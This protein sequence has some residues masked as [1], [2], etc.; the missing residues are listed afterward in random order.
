MNVNLAFTN[1]A[2]GTVNKSAGAGNL[3]FNNSFDNDGLVGP[4]DF[5][6]LKSRFGQAGFPDQDLNGDGMVN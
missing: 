2:I 1:G 3:R 6:L 4:F 5:S